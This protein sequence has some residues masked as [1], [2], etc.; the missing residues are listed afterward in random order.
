MS[1]P[2]PV[3]LLGYAAATLT[4]LSFFPQAIQTVR[5]GDTRGISLPMYVLFTTGICLWGLYGLLTRDGPLIVANAIT[6]V[7]AVVVLE[8]K[9]RSGRASSGIRLW[10]GW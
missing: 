6:L 9:L 5:S 3:S 7:P 4:T 2:L 10:R 1:Q 8:R